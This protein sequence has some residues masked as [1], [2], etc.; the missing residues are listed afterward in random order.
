[1]IRR[2]TRLMAVPFAAALLFAL[3]SS[4]QLAQ[5]PGELVALTGARLIDGTGRA[6]IQ[7]ATLLVRSS[8]IEA[9]GASTDVQIPAAAVRILADAGVPVAMGTDSGAQIGRWQ[10]YVEHIEMELMVKAG[11]TPM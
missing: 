6:P 10:G 9:A 4:Q 8:R 7:Q 5:A 3:S 2:A 11:L 1:M